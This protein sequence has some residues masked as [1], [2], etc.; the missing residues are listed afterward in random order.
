MVV[1]GEALLPTLAWFLAG[2]NA[3]SLDVAIPIPG[4]RQSW[5]PRVLELCTMGIVSPVAAVW[6]LATLVQDS[7]A[8]QVAMLE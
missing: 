3:V 6:S 5:L 2:A 8:G 7:A 1:E 4:G